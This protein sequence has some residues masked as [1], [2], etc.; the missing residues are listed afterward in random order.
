MKSGADAVHMMPV[1]LQPAEQILIA[2]RRHWAYLAWKLIPQ[3]LLAILGAAAF[4]FILTT[5]LNST[6]T[7]ILLVLAGLWT[8]L[9]A[10][11]SYFVWYRYQNDVWVI[12]NQRIVD[13]LRKHWFH[14][15][16]ASADLIDVEDMS[17]KKE[18]ILPTMFNFGDVRCQTAGV[19]PNFILAG[20][21]DPKEAMTVIDNARDVARKALA[22]PQF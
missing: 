11:R 17:I 6:V 18:G 21:P 12:T 9:F 14:H 19:A 7:L 4:I 15:Q 5:S 10:I 3:A 8:V 1:D 20:I 2:S 16:L 13:S 22:R